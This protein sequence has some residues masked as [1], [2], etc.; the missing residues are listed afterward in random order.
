MR[1]NYWISCPIRVYNPAPDVWEIE[2]NLYLPCIASRSP[3]LPLPL[4]LVYAPVSAPAARSRRPPAQPLGLR[5]PIRVATRSVFILSLSRFPGCTG[6]PLSALLRPYQI[7]THTTMNGIKTSLAFPLH[8]NHLHPFHVPRSAAGS[9]LLLSS[10]SP[11]IPY[12]CNLATCICKIMAS[13]SAFHAYQPGTL[14][15]KIMDIVAESVAFPR[16]PTNLV[17]TIGR[18][19]ASPK[20][21]ESHARHCLTLP[22]SLPSVY[23]SSGAFTGGRGGVTQQAN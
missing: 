23:S 18:R 2:Y 19:L 4:S 10:P 12:S 9:I 17:R 11:H 22:W 15:S 13:I 20:R 7:F 5:P 6:P 8:N 21:V 14:T 3:H 16:L 1:G